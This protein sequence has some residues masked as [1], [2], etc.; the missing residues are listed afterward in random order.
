MAAIIQ[1]KGLITTL[2]SSGDAHELDQLFPG[3]IT[4]APWKEIMVPRL[5]DIKTG[6]SLIFWNIDSYDRTRLPGVHWGRLENVIATGPNLFR[7][8]LPP[9]VMSDDTSYAG[10]LVLLFNWYKSEETFDPINPAPDWF[11]WCRQ[12]PGY[13]PYK[14]P[15]G[16]FDVPTL[17]MRIFGHRKNKNP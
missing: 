2:D 11:A 7:G 15:V 10:W 3:G 1:A 14:A 13:G 17:A 9:G 6:D 16:F 12:R 4:T 5:A 8:W